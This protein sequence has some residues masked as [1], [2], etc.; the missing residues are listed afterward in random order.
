MILRKIQCLYWEN[1]SYYA[2]H[3]PWYHLYC[4]LYL[5]TWFCPI[6]TSLPRY[7]STHYIPI[8]L[9]T[10]SHHLSIWTWWHYHPWPPL[11]GLPRWFPLSKYI[12]C[13]SFFYRWS[14]SP[15]P[16]WQNIHSLFHSLYVCFAVHWSAKTQPASEAHSTDSEVCTFYL[17]TKMVQWLRPIL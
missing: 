3:P 10:P 5:H 1:T 16:Q 11:R 12:Q 2:I 14:R 15:R 9:P 13:T 4:Q 8:W 7:Q 6:R 17:A